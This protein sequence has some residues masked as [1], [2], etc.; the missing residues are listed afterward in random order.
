MTDFIT[1][2]FS[3]YDRWSRDPFLGSLVFDLQLFAA[4]DEGRTEEPTEKKLREAREKGQVA[5]TVE[6]PQAAVV[7]FGFMVILIFGSWIYNTI[8]SIARHY[9]SSFSRF[10]VTERSI[11][12]EFMMVGFESGKILL[13]VFIAVIIAAILGNIIQVGFQVST[14]PLKFDLKKIKFDPATVMKRVL[15]SKQVAMNLFKS[16]FKVLA[17]GFVAYLIIMSDLGAI[18][19]TPDV[20]IAMALRTIMMTAFKIIIWSAVLLLV[21]S[22]P[23]YFFQK[24]EFIESLKMT[25]EEMK[26]ELKETIGDPYVRARLREMQRQN[27]LRAMMSRE[28]PKADVIVTNPTH[29]AVALKYDRVLM[30]APTVVAKGEDSIALRIRELAKEHGVPIIE[31]RPLAQEMYR[32]LEVGEIIPEDLFYAVSLIYGELYRSFP[33]RFKYLREAI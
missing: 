33:E 7:I 10:H 9:L 16:V 13:P 1:Y 4:E 24:R 22:I 30:P 25:K 18:L 5:R 29:Y 19:R 23:D 21:L 6:L 27:L 20:S 26:E 8:A 11:F 14:H 2:T 3:K 31:N 17:I 32:R 12:Q 28:V 15:F